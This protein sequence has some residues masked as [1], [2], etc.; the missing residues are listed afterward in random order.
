M[1]CKQCAVRLPGCRATLLKMQPASCASRAAVGKAGVALNVRAISPA[2]HCPCPG[3]Q[4]HLDAKGYNAIAMYDTINCWVRHVSSAAAGGWCAVQ[5]PVR[6][7]T[8]W[9]R[10]LPNEHSALPWLHSADQ[11]RGCDLRRCHGGSA[12]V[13]SYNTAEPC[14]HA[15]KA[16]QK[17]CLM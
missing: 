5:L 10:H 3:L 11:H 6:T 12:I 16:S 9:C 13:Q 7:H 17:D 2:L 1:L 4:E 14:D 15:S 8:K